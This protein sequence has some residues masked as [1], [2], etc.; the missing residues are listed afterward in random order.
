MQHLLVWWVK[1][2]TEKIKNPKA[3]PVI[4][5]TQTLRNGYFRNCKGFIFCLSIPCMQITF[6]CLTSVFFFR[7][8]L[9]FY[10]LGSKRSMLY[11]WSTHW[12]W[13]TDLSWRVLTIVLNQGG[14]CA[15]VVERSFNTLPRILS[16]FLE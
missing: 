16:S 13:I 2:K 4:F 11:M 8:S 6:S 12:H 10:P 3:E 14:E 7:I 15:A 1:N 9:G 5:I